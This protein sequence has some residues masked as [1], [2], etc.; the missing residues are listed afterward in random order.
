MSEVIECIIDV[1]GGCLF[2]VVQ[3]FLTSRDYT[4]SGHNVPSAVH[5]EVG[6]GGHQVFRHRFFTPSTLPL[7]PLASI[8]GELISNPSV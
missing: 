7:L 2:V 3:T 4:S 6:E 8:H 5:G 1:D